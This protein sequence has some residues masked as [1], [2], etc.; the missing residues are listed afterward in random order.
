MDLVLKPKYILTTTLTPEGASEFTPTHK[1]IVLGDVQTSFKVKNQ[2]IA[3]KGDKGDAL[4]GY[5]IEA[6]I[7]T[8]VELEAYYIL[9]KS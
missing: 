6:L 9:A 8:N 1:S 3:L 5:D 7:P 4:N 2:V